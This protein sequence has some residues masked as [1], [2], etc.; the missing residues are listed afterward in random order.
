MGYKQK[1]PALPEK[2]RGVLF[3]TLRTVSNLKTL[4]R[5]WAMSKVFE[6][7]RTRKPQWTFVA[8]S[9]DSAN[10]AGDAGENCVGI[11]ANQP[12]CSDYDNQNYS[13]HHS[14]LCNVLAIVGPESQKSLVHRSA[15][16][17]NNC[18]RG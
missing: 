8:R 14:V 10:S 18:V 11:R 2:E 7:S 5:R 16:R 15:F 4:H 1:T 3:R 13:H 6:S 12:D 17:C 9:G